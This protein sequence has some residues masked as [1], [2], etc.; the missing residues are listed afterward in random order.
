MKIRIFSS[1]TLRLLLVVG[2]VTIGACGDDGDGDDTTVIL[3]PDNDVERE[4]AG[5]AQP[6]V[7]V[8]NKIDNDVK[9]V[10]RTKI[11]NN[12]DVDI[13]NDQLDLDWDCVSVDEV[14][15]P[16]YIH[17]NVININ[18]EVRCPSVEIDDVN[19][20]G[21]ID[22]AEAE[23][24]VGPRRIALDSNPQSQEVEDFPVGSSY[25]YNEEI[26]LTKLQQFVAPG[27]N[28]AVLIYGADPSTPL[29]ATYA[30]T[31]ATPQ[32]QRHLT[33]P[34]DCRIINSP[35][36]IGGN[37]TTTGGTAGGTATGT[38]GGGGTTTGGATTGGT[39]SGSTTG[40]VLIQ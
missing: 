33:V 14:E 40:G 34:V 21:V 9:V 36:I 6:S 23:A 16:Q 32:D 29:P 26:P 19:S 4:E 35:I 5:T 28:V 18:V 37:N 38:A 1:K 20:D 30:T 39:T 12:N 31:E 17:V 22:Q 27:Q 8:N 15:H 2:M 11:V 7:V 10:D 24:V 25:T 13:D 3:S